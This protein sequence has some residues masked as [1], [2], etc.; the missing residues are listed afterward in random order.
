MSNRSIEI[1]ESKHLKVINSARSSGENEEKSS[2]VKLVKRES[3]KKTSSSVSP[4][5]L[6]ETWKQVFRLSNFLAICSSVRNV[7]VMGQVFEKSM[8]STIF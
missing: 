5:L 7:A 2:K 6:K 4:N 3:L 8:V 1:E